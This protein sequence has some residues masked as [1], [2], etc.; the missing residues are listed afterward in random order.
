LDWEKG[1]TDIIFAGPISCP[2]Q[3]EKG[4]QLHFDVTLINSEI[5]RLTEAY[6]P[7]F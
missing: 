7:K 3:E 5:E 2:R 4:L 1:I 6:I